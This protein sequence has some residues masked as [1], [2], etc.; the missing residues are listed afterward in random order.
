MPV[1]CIFVIQGDI[2]TINND[3]SF[4]TNVKYSH[5]PHGKS[6]LLTRHYFG[7][8]MLIAEAST[9]RFACMTYLAIIYSP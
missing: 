6:T 5:F 8:G 2:I 1:L 3:V 7:V 4:V 9:P